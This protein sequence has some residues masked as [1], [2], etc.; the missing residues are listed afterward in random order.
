MCHRVTIFSH[1]FG[2]TLQLHFVLYQINIMPQYPI[3]DYPRLNAPCKITS[4]LDVPYNSVP[5]VTLP[6]A[7]VPR[8][9]L[10]H[11][12]TPHATLPHTSIIQ[13]ALPYI[14]LLMPQ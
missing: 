7:S 6:H 13:K 4:Y 1:S 11:A 2:V 9:I 8:T 12:S 10:L 3:Y 14:T 5:R